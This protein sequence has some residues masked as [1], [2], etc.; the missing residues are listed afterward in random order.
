[1]IFLKKHRTS[2]AILLAGIISIMLLIS[3]DGQPDSTILARVGSKEISVKQFLQRSELT[4]RPANF[5]EKQTTL[6]NLIMEKILALAAERN[7]E[8][9]PNANL[10][11]KL[12]GI[13][14]QLMRDKLYYEVAYNTVVLDSQEIRDV[15]RVSM[16]TYNLEFFTVH[17][18]HLVQKIAAV[19][20]WD[21]ELT[22][23]M[24]KEVAA[25]LK[26][27]PLHQIAYDDPED[28]QIHRALFTRPVPAGTV[29][30]PIRLGNGDHIIMK[31]LDWV[32]FP[33]VSGEDQQI[34]WNRVQ[35]NL[36]RMKAGKVWRSYQAGVMSGKKVEFDKQSFALLADLALAKY[37]NNPDSSTW[38]DQFPELPYN[39]A[40]IDL[41]APFFTI[42]GKWW[43]IG[44]F[45]T[46]LIKHPLV[47][48]TKQLTAVNFP[49]QF[50]LAVVDM[51]RD[52]YLTQE[53]YK[54]ALDKSEEIDQTMAMWQDAYLAVKQKEGIIDSAIAKGILTGNDNLAT[55]KYWQSYLGALQGRYGDDIQINHALFDSISLTEVDFAAVRPGV[56]YPI[57]VPGFPLLISS[58]DLSYVREGGLN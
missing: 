54:R 35:K 6:N 33:L 14:E 2:V 36:L 41:N 43:T 31:V 21:P 52:F 23:E 19:V 29:I 46:E 12:T 5:K 55:L 7:P 45:K 37:V 48:R 47:F 24:F 27:R 3:C 16:R 22:D 15:Y 30:G 49:E 13:R 1:M 39:E 32:D 8:F 20:D 57:A 4:I 53:A 56:P 34:R 38:T 25:I 11:L 51:I 50:K 28:E 9:S 17:D 18:P 42:D 58:A 44:D 10:Q 40:E 26:K